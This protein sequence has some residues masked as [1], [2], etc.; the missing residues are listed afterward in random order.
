MV[1]MDGG[2]P[3]NGGAIDAHAGI[4]R[5]NNAYTVLAVE[6]MLNKC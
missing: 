2:C 4:D 1:F 5:D 6:F 3:A